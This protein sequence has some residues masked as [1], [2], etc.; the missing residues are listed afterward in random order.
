MAR[1]SILIIEDEDPKRKHIEEHIKSHLDGTAL[2]IIFFHSVSSSLDYLDD[3]EPELI[4]L[5]MSLPTYDISE[6]EG[7]GRPQGFGGLEILRHLKMSGSSC[8][9]LVLTGYE[10]FMR[11]EGL[12]E[13]SQISDELK[14]EF[15]KFL[16]DV[17]YYN[18]AYSEWKNR[19]SSTLINLGLFNKK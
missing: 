19:I 1:R 3:N 8:P 12:V 2:D 5:D 18:S 17:L 11:E 15:G 13:L 9:T 7:G 6:I 10:A 16:I 14:S 4:I